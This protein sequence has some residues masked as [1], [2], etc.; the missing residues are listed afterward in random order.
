VSEHIAVEKEFSKRQARALARWK[1]LILGLR[2]RQRLQESYR[3]TTKG[4]GQR[5]ASDANGSGV[6]SIVEEGV[7]EVSASYEGVAGSTIC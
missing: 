5:Q 4:G 6:G 1:K 3:E 2:I 7:S